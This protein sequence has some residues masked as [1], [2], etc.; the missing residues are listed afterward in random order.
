MSS[1]AQKKKEEPTAETVVALPVKSSKK[2]KII[3]AIIVIVLLGI[4]GGAAAYFMGQKD[5]DSKDAKKAVVKAAPAVFLPLENFVVNLQSE[6]GDKYLQAG[7]TLQV[8]NAEQVEYYKTNMPQV[9]SR[10]IMLLSSKSADE[11]LTNPGKVKLMDEIIKNVQLPYSKDQA[12]PE[13]AEE[14]KVLGVDFTSFVVQ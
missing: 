8:K 5:S 13:E 1:S 4:A 6:N 2:K 10:I 9:R 7:I 11:L 12:S 14:H 3:I